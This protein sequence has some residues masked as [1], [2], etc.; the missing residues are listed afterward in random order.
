M[1]NTICIFVENA[2]GTD[3]D[4][5]HKPRVSTSRRPLCGKSLLQCSV[6]SRPSRPLARLNNTAGSPPAP[7]PPLCS[8][9][10]PR[11]PRRSHAMPN[12]CTTPQSY[13]GRRPQAPAA[14]SP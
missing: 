13:S 1:G 2:T 11:Q 14:L 6:T 5:K 3:R 7:H 10:G 12:T 9:L 4:G 8:L